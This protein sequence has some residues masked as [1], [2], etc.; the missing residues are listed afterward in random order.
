MIKA[1]SR[2]FASNRW[3]YPTKTS[4]YTAGIRPVL[5]DGATALCSSEHGQECVTIDINPFLVWLAHSKRHAIRRKTSL[6]HLNLGNNRFLWRQKSPLNFTLYLIYITLIADG[7]RTRWSLYNCFARQLVRRRRK[8]PQFVHSYCLLSAELWWGY[9]TQPS[10]ISQCPSRTAI[11]L[12][13]NSRLTTEASLRQMPVLCW[14]GKRKF[15]RYCISHPRRRLPFVRHSMWAFWHIHHISTVRQSNIILGVTRLAPHAILM[16][17]NRPKYD[18][19]DSINFL[20]ATQQTFTAAE[21]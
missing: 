19:P 13:R 6:Q 15:P 16:T 3:G 11:G 9:R 2:V 4:S 7:M 10:T 14:M 17:M 1:N 20:I 8:N 21:G 18:K 12:G 5:W